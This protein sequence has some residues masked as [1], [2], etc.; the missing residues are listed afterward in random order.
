MAD[1]KEYPKI[2]GDILYSG[3][4]N[5]LPI[6]DSLYVIKGAGDGLE[7]D[8]I[9]AANL[10]DA[11]YVKI[12][13]TSANSSTGAS[14]YLTIQTKEVGGEYADS[15]AQTEIV[16]ITTAHSLTATGSFIWHHTLTAG[17]KTN[18]VQVK[19]ILSGI[20]NI[21]TTLELIKTV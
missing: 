10:T 3:D 21:M 15:L 2:D 12:S 19:V 6:Y 11:K 13:V 17:E 18:G 20:T 9:S 14:G 4:V 5:L 1:A 8:A 16:Y 7:F